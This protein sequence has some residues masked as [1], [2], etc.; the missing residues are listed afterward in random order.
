[1]S[2]GPTCHKSEAKVPRCLTELSQGL[3]WKV[4]LFSHRSVA[5]ENVGQALWCIMFG[6]TARFSDLDHVQYMDLTYGHF[7][8]LAIYGVVK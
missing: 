1:M 7:C 8:E 6:I 3:P 4:Q 2:Q 5:Y